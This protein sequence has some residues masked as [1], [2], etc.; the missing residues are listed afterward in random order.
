VAA[1]S[2]RSDN[3]EILYFVDTMTA[4]KAGITDVYIH[5]RGGISWC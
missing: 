4:C 2:A 5:Q 3:G 1:I